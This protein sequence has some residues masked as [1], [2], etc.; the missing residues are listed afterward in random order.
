MSDRDT[1]QRCK[2]ALIAGTKKLDPVLNPIGFFFELEYVDQTHTGSYANGY[3][4][5][6]GMS[7]GLI[8]RQG[9]GLGHVI[10]ANEHKNIS[11]NEFMARIGN[12]EQSKLDYQANC[13]R[14]FGKDGSDPFDALAYDIENFA[15]NILSGKKSGFDKVLKAKTKKR[16]YSQDAKIVIGITLS[17]AIGIILD[18]FLG[19]AFVATL[20]GLGVGVIGGIAYRIILNKKND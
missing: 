10:Y 8:Y 14:S 4:R 1:Q 5:K 7:I 11:H 13:S 15:L 16:N 2:N 18:L 19:Y 12:L 9:A 20:F 3:Y 6:D 17:T